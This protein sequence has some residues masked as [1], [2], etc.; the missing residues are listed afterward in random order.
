MPTTL[1]REQDCEIRNCDS[2]FQIFFFIPYVN[3]NSGRNRYS[4][5]DWPPS[6]RFAQLFP[7]D[8]LPVKG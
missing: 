5:V 4:C 3:S 2:T 8:I 7:N 1:S 6:R